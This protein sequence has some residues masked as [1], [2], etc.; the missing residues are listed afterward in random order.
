MSRELEV[1]G[2]RFLFP[3][4]WNALKYDDSV[5]HRNQFQSFA[6]GSKALDAVAISP[7]SVLWLIEVKDYR[8]NPRSKVSSVFSEVAAKVKSTLAGLATA[9]VRANDKAENDF[10]KQ[11]MSTKGLRVVLHLDQPQHNSRLFKQVVDPR[12]ATRYL[13]DKVRAVD[14][15]AICC[16]C[17]VTAAKLPWTIETT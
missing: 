1:D 7:D 13:R 15:H 16:G 17:G 4:G 14:P 8:H 10:A 5:F 3:A 6:G 9:R 2:L 12:T 11:A